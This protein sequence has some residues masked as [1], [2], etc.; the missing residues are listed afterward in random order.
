MGVLA[1]EWVDQWFL[2]FVQ[3]NLL[4][5]LVV[6]NLGVVKTSELGGGGIVGAAIVFIP[7]P[8]PAVL[9]KP[10]VLEIP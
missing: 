10:P 3:Q 7:N 6:H 1:A 5:T 4:N 2:T 8:V 9:G